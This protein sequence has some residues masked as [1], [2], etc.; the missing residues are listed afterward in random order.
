MEMTEKARDL[1]ALASAECEA[2]C[3]V[4]V[5]EYVLTGEGDPPEPSLYGLSQEEAQPL[6]LAVI[7]IEGAT[8]ASE[9]AA[10]AA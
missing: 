4:A 5:R 10:R 1:R 3:I 6:A 7:V 2:A 8:G 9:L